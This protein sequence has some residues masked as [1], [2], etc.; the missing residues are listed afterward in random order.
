MDFLVVTDWYNHSIPELCPIKP[1]ISVKLTY[2]YLPQRRE[3]QD[4]CQISVV[5]F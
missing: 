5:S 3:L 1:N 2:K 4:L